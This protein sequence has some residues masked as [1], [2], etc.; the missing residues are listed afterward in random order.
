[1]GQAYKNVWS[2]NV[3]EVVTA[4]M[5]RHAFGKGYEV[6]MPLN[7]QAKDIDLLVFNATTKKVVTIQVK[8]SRAYVPNKKQLSKHKHGSA[9]WFWFKKDIVLKSIADFFVYLVYV[10]EEDQKIGRSFLTHHFIVIPTQDLKNQYRQHGRILK[11]NR[12]N[13]ILWINPKQKK[14]FDIRNAAFDLSPWLNDKGI[15]VL[16]DSLN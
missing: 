9:G 3:D 2:L 12:F 4:G 14:A 5:L 8:G 11:G 7:A 13:L 10:I 15:M 1:M 16:K 6:C